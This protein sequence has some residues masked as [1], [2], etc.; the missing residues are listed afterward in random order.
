MNQSISFSLSTLLIISDEETGCSVGDYTISS[1]RRW[2]YENNCAAIVCYVS[3]GLATSSTQLVD[4]SD[5]VIQ[6]HKQ[7][8]QNITVDNI[9]EILLY[10]VNKLLKAKGSPQPL[11]VR[12][13]NTNNQA[14]IQNS[15]NNVHSN[16]NIISARN[17]NTNNNHN[18]NAQALPAIHLKL[19]Y[20]V[21][22][23]PPIDLVIKTI[24]DFK[25][26]NSSVIQIAF[27]LLPACNLQNFSTFMS[28][29]GI[30]HE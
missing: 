1:R 14:N 21:S 5:D 30:R 27:T 9:N 16:N 29:C 4:L 8:A 28:I 26:Q 24:L 3:T 18:N 20:Q 17:N 6:H 25:E 10:T 22:A 2:N 11:L 23:S 15:E 13:D 7:L 19:F 12:S